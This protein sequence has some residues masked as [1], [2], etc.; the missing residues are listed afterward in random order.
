MFRP[1]DKTNVDCK[2]AKGCLKISV[3]SNWGRFLFLI[4]NRYGLL[5]S[6]RQEE[7]CSLERFKCMIS[8]HTKSWRPLI[9]YLL[10]K[11]I[12]ILMMFKCP[13][14]ACMK[15]KYDARF[16][17]IK[18]W[19]FSERIRILCRVILRLSAGSVW[20]PA[21]DECTKE[22]LN[23]VDLVYKKKELCSS[24][25]LVLRTLWSNKKEF[26]YLT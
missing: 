16:V 14:V 8:G 1:K 13:L 7:F 5:S 18:I 25:R 23:K 6:W 15:L 4:G 10:L 3:W 22:I 11:K 17:A 21:I 2:C 20:A 19:F 12:S 24:L 26:Q 9:M